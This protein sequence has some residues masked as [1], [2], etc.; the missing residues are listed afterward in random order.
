MVIIPTTQAIHL[1]KKL[2][3]SKKFQ[4]ILPGFN[5]DGKRYF[6]DGEIY[7]KIPEAR[8]LK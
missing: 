6:P 1:A 7:A 5:R 2:R 8:R 3:G 4:I